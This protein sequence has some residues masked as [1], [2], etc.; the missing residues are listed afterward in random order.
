MSAYIALALSVGLLAVLDTWLYVGPLAAVLPGLVW[1]SFIAWGCHFHSGG[2][3]KGMTTAIVGMSFGALVGMVAVLLA[4]GAFAGLG[5]MA[6]PVA[7]GL[8]AFVIC[9]ASRL[10]LLATIPA[11]VYGFASVAGPVLLA[12]LTPGQAIG[13][14]IGSIIIGALFGIAS[15]Y[16]ANAMTAKGAVSAEEAA[17]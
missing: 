2:G 1:I 17:V 14:V 15:E 7:V 11:S 16:L 13:P 5:Q 9:L 4:G 6:A 8:G 3:V 10:P 12:E